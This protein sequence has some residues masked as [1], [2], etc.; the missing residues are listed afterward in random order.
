MALAD[1]YED[2]PPGIPLPAV[3]P[4]ANPG[5]AA[6]MPGSAGARIL[7]AE[8]EPHAL[9][10]LEELLG[11]LGYEVMACNDPTAALNALATRR[12]DVLLTDV[13][14]PGLSGL[15][16]AAAAVRIDPELRI[17]LMSGY[18]PEGGDR[19]DEWHFLRK[20]LQVGDLAGLLARCCTTRP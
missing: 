9:E 11:D 19:R 20:P 10:A 15:E 2:G 3:P 6:S 13:I 1:M 16:L 17:I 4:V 5:K 8:D 12:F 18:L 14:M 7:I